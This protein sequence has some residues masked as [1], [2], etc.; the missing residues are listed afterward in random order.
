MESRKGTGVRVSRGKKIPLSSRPER[1]IRK[2]ECSVNYNSS[3]F[4]SKEQGR[5]VG[6]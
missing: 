6:D 3:P 5:G 2:L 1:E 4:N